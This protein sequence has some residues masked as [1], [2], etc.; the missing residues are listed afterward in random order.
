[1]KLTH[2]TDDSL[3]SLV[4]NFNAEGW[5]LFCQA[6]QGQTHLFLIG[7]GLGLNGNTDRRFRERNTLKHN[8]IVWITKSVASSSL[9]ETNNGGNIT[10]CDL[11]YIFTVI[12][13]HS[14]NS[15]HTLF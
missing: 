4:I 10:S 6:L 1:M 15:A 9:L 12:S 2:A 11:R 5:V 8:W 14:D 7:F 3:A 13:M